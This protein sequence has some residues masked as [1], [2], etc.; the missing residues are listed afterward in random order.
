M[1]ILLLSAVLVLGAFGVQGQ[2][3]LTCH[4]DQTQTKVAFSATLKAFDAPWGAV[5]PLPQDTVMVYK[6]VFL[7]LGGAY[8]HTTGIFTA[9]VN[10]VYSFNFHIYGYSSI[11]MGV[12]LFK[13]EQRISTAYDHPS[14][15]STDTASNSALLSLNKGD[16][17][18]IHLWADHQVY[19]SSNNHNT[20]NGFLVFPL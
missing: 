14:S 7:N 1:K 11:K 9:P 19:M 6:G 16:E 2:R 12:S 10:G 20:F 17:V 13:N 5:G 18:T 3:T 15:D 8:N 4:E